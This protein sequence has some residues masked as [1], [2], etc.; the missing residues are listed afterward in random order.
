VTLL[1]S[2]DALRSLGA[3][4]GLEAEQT[5]AL[6]GPAEAGADVGMGV[7]VGLGIKTL[8]LV[9]AVVPA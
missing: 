8:A 3:L 1:V 4:P 2:A 7:G 5:G 9:F 6:A